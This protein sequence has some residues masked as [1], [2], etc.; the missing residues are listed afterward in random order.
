[1]LPWHGQL[2]AHCLGFNGVGNLMCTALK[3]PGRQ[4]D[5]T[6]T[7]I[8]GDQ[9]R[10][11]INGPRKL[12]LCTGIRKMSLV[13]WGGCLGGRNRFGA[14]TTKLTEIGE[15]L[16]STLNSTIMIMIWMMAATNDNRRWLNSKT[17]AASH[18]PRRVL[19]VLRN[20]WWHQS[21]SRRWKSP[22]Q[23]CLND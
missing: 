16:K 10:L 4:P 14:M 1:M 7:T 18:T 8:G 6:T 12:N 3:W 11:K 15:Y 21:R 22:V 20:R 17:L 19:A 2:N 23:R 13:I 9:K 5:T